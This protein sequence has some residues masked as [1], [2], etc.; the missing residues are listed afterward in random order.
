MNRRDFLLQEM[1]I[2]QWVLTKPQVLKGDAQ[3][4][5]APHI[6]FV[7][8]CEEDHQHTGLFQ[9]ILRAL[10][11]NTKQ[12]QWLN[13]EQAVRLALTH[14]PYF[15]LI[16]PKQQAVAFTKKFANQTAWHNLSWQELQQTAHKRQFWQQI[17]P[18]T[19]NTEN[20]CN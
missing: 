8:V 10:G 9:D 2:T 14:S 1:N 7:V 19:L 13:M 6:K 18:F 20:D 11:L 3:I 12:Y 4:R 16:Q 15:W 5:L 17:E